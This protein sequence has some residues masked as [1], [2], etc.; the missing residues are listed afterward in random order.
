[1]CIQPVGAAGQGVSAVS[2]S[3]P[4]TMTSPPPAP[5]LNGTLGGIAQQLGM[6][7]SSVQSSLKQGAS[8]TDLAAQQSV[9]RDAI[10]A[11]VQSQIQ[12]T[13]QANGLPA[14][15]PTVLNRMVN[16]AFDSSRRVSS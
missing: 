8:I 7:T 6:S 12:S 16:R 10:A 5:A 1:M 9:S 14:A 11:S 13:R 2:A 4:T 15:D 3:M